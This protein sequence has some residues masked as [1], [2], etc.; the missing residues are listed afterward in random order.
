[1]SDLPVSLSG[2]SGRKMF[3][4]NDVI[5]YGKS[6]ICKVEEI[7]TISLSM[8][9]K[10][11]EYYTLCPIYQHEA[12]IYVPVDNSKTIMRPVISKAE[13][14]QLIEE[15][16]KIQTV[17]IGNERER[18]AQYRSALSTC[19]CRELVKIIKTL[20]QRKKS[21][22]RDGKKVTVVDER[23]FRMAED[24]L[25]GE[26]AYVLEIDKNQVADYIADSIME[27]SES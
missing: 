19:D 24:Q 3:E 20:Y 6:G 15:I 7:G 5:V 13:A 25:Y 21:R 14:K 8:A 4:V 1:M 12:V 11:R 23:Y 26:L 10:K 16:P 27:K 9:D 17:W 22:I 2:E 18:E